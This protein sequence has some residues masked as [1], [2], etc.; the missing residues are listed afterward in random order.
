MNFIHEKANI[1]GDV[2][3]GDGVSVWPFASIR[4]DEGKIII[5]DNTNIQDNAV[6][7]GGTMIGKNVTVGHGAVIYKAKIGNNVIIG[8]NAT[9]LDNAEIGDWCII[10]ANSLVPP[11][12]KID[13]E[14]IVMGIPGKVTRK[15]EEKDKDYITKACNNYLDKI[16]RKL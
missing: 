6:I 1:E 3:L 2:E 16:E 12:A 9:I 4:G 11:S 13:P 14:S 8:I 7:H 15:L 10:V 5:G